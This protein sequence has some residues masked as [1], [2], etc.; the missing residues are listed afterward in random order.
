M[1]CKQYQNP[2][3]HVV[4]Y[5][6]EVL[7]FIYRSIGSK[8]LPLSKLALLHFDSH[9]DLGIPLDID[10]SIVFNKVE[11]YEVISIESWILPAVYAGHFD[12]I[13]WVKPPWANQISDGTYTFCVGED[14]ESMKLKASLKN[15]YFISDG[16]F[17]AESGMN[18]NKPL[19]LHV[20]TAG[21][22][23]YVNEIQH[24]LQNKTHFILDIDLDFFSTKNPF[25][26][27]FTTEE[28]NNL[29]TI[30]HFE[31]LDYENMDDS[32]ILD[33]QENRLK[34]LYEIENIWTK[35]RLGQCN[36]DN[37]NKT[38]NILRNI[39]GRYGE[40]MH[41]SLDEED[42]DILHG[43]GCTTGDPSLPHHISSQQE[44]E[45]FVSMV[46]D[47]LHCLNKP[48]IVTIAR[49]SV[50]DYCPPHQV[51]DIQQSV[52]AMLMSLFPTYKVF[53]HYKDDSM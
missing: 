17:Q 14:K 40:V 16:V 21:G 45:M 34:Q 6:H 23:E 44:I 25:Q 19:T 36:E 12:T 32:E 8:H 11:L 1:Y 27:M 9:P 13:I 39:S 49:S 26:E 51:D 31:T 29:T 2:P 3:I 43:A 35:I 4:E 37:E 10:S 15:S 46:Q 48:S 33:I 5:H 28:L 38:F 53:H 20:I 52:L 24:I 18:N 30:Y 22:D 41:K 50:D 7:P 47:I 42:F